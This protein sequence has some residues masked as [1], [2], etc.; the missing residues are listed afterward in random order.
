MCSFFHLEPVHCFMSSSNCFFL[1]CIWI[2]QESSKVV[3][4][5]HLFKTFPWFVVIHTVPGSSAGKESTCNAGDLGLNPGLGR[6]PGE[7]NGYPLQYSCLKNPMDRGDWRATVHG[8]AKSQTR[9][10]DW[11]LLTYFRQGSPWKAGTLSDIICA[12][13]TACNL[14]LLTQWQLLP[15]FLP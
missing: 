10:N 2:S 15:G 11:R 5:F 14:N 3:W 6:C 7:G 8:V 4:Y 9:L 1:T 12:L 13:K